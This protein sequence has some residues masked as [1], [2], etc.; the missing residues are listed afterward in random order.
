[1]FVNTIYIH[2]DGHEEDE[3]EVRKFSFGVFY[4]SST[5]FFHKYSQYIRTAF[6]FAIEHHLVQRGGILL[7]DRELLDQDSISK[8][9]MLIKVENFIDSREFYKKLRNS[10]DNIC[11]QYE[12][13]VNQINEIES[14]VLDEIFDI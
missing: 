3:S 14:S 8:D 2:H 5:V 6:D 12:L 13:I 11:D 7:I 10:W 4:G 9:P 1:K